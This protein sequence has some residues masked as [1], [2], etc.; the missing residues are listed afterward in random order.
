MRH[1]GSLPTEP[2]ARRFSDYLYAQG[3]DNKIE[4]AANAANQSA[5]WQIWVYAEEQISQAQAFLDEYRQAPAAP[6]FREIAATAQQKRKQAQ[7]DLNAYRKRILTKQQ[8]F[9]QFDRLGVL[10]VILIGL[11][12]A[13]AVVLKLGADFTFARYLFIS[14]YLKAGLPEI[15]HGQIWRL[16]TPIF[17][18]FGIMHI[19]FNMLWLRDLG[20]MIEQRQSSWT[21]A[22]LVLVIAVASN[23]GQFLVS[24]PLFGGMSGVVYG[25]FGYIWM[26]GKYDFSSNLFVHPQTVT[27]MIIWF[28]VC[29]VG[30]V[31][32]VANTAHG[33]GFAI[34]M[35]WGFISAKI[36][37]RKILRRKGSQ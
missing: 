4:T 17:I 35:A 15:W 11:S 2:D 19:F 22:A 10:T 31:G 36:A 28:V 20:S 3:L 13:V 5:D 23:V 37:T 27:M 12:V 21:L 34:G 16:V 29:L 30:L 32:N 14:E 33:V 7:Q 18:H 26:R 24:G 8:I 1:I 25:L 9:P 6:Q